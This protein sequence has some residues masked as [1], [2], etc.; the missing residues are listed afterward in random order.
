[1]R[2][3]LIIP[4]FALLLASCRTREV[5]SAGPPPPVPVTVAVATEESVPEE[6]RAIGSVEPAAT[7][8]I[9]SQI[10]GQLNAIHFVEGGNVKKGD[11]LFEIDPRPYQDALR[12]TEATVNRDRAQFRQA[13]ANLSKDQAQWKNNETL[14]ARY[15]SLHKEGVVSREQSEQMRT[16]E[17]TIRESVQAD[18]AAVESARAAVETDLA[19]VERAKLDLSYCQ[20]R[21]PIT[22]RA[23]NLLVHA[24]NLVK[25]SDVPLVVINQIEPIFVSF[26]VPQQYLAAIRSNS[27][28]RKLPIHVALQEA[29]DKTA[30]GFLS[31]I[32]NTVDNTTGTIR[33]KGSF[34]NRE[35]ILWPGQL[36]NAT[37]TLDTLSHVTVVPSEAVQAGQQGSFIYVVKQPDQTVERRN[38]TVGPVVNKRIVIE[39]G[40]TPGETVVIDGQL[41]LFPNAHIRPVS[42]NNL[43]PGGQ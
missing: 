43:N 26:G 30:N 13:E 11:L 17:Q 36:V 33:L 41:R 15:E 35:R 7:V 23:G 4:V 14:A 6:I 28:T 40:V 9:K 29:P 38:V 12:Q 27:A 20:I 21:S 2:K 25:V 1:P 5:K 34:D 31:V 42:P 10:A 37:L 18:S 8:Q 16:N 32:D 19:A 39:K 22:G 3:L 24:G